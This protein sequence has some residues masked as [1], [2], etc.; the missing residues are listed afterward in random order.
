[1]LKKTSQDF[2]KHI[3]IILATKIFQS[4]QHEIRTCKLAVQGAQKDQYRMPGSEEHLP[5]SGAWPLPSRSVGSVDSLPTA[6]STIGSDGSSGT[7]G[8]GT[9]SAII[10]VLCFLSLFLGFLDFARA[11]RSA[12]HLQRHQ[13]VKN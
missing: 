1:M 2:K 5:F 3:Q 9:S 4:E 8:G 13:S 10:D 6:V 12:L 11:S 7:G